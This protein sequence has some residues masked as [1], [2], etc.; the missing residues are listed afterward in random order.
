ME[1]KKSRY[2]YIDLLRGWAVLV[3]IETHVINAF[4]LPAMRDTSWFKVLNFINGLVAPSFLFIAGYSFAMIAQRKWND[5]LSFNAVFRKQVGRILQVLLVGYTLHIPFFSFNKLCIIPWE[6]WA[7]FWKVDVLHCIASSLLFLL[8]TVIVTRTPKRFLLTTS[9]ICGGVI[10][11]TPL[12]YTA[13]FD[14]IFPV[15]IANYLNAFHGSLFPLFP[16]MGFILMGAILGQLVTLFKNKFGETSVFKYIFIAGAAIIISALIIATLP[17]TVY[18]PH[19][20]WRA[21]PW[22]YFIRLGIVLLIL[23]TLWYWEQTAK[24]GKSIVSVVGSESLVAYAGHLLVIYGLFFDGESFSS[25]IGRTRTVPE[26]IGMAVILLTATIFV[27][28]I[29]NVIK[30]KSMLYARIVQYTLLVIVLYVFFT[31][32][33]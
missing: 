2:V 7:N 8:L 15:P 3:M 31:K 1:Q 13:N 30:N 29:W 9:I 33:F 14:S 4:M 27:S 28:Y 17:F 19:N 18:P 11:L 32:P 20:F 12:M 22:F 24:S 21:S 23:A 25:L 6:E 16:W 26:V 5:Y 10:F